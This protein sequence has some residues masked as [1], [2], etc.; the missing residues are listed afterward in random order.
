MLVEWSHPAN[1]K[2]VFEKREIT[3]IAMKTLPS[4]KRKG[5]TLVELL[6]VIAII[7]VLA[8]AGFSAGL[9]ALQRAKRVTALNMGTGIEQAINNFYDEYGYLPDPGNNPV[10]IVF[11]SDNQ[12]LLLILSGE[13]TATEPQNTKSINYLNLQEGDPQPGGGINGIVY[14]ENSG[15]PIGIYDPWGEA[16]YIVVDY[17]YDERIAKERIRP[18]AG[19][20]RNLNKRRVAV[21]SNGADATNGRT[22]NAADDVSTW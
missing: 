9:A 19:T 11:E 8:A 5:F 4:R 13:E 14:D 12:Q 16:F 3:T 2:G 18:K 1:S 17:N 6:V 22:G 15:V 10:D 21:W 7:A 20:T